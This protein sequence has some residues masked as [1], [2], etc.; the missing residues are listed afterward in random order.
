MR[1]FSGLIFR[2]FEKLILR[3]FISHNLNFNNLSIQSCFV[4]SGARKSLSHVG[5]ARPRRFF[6]FQKMEIAKNRVIKVFVVCSQKENYF[7]LFKDKCIEGSA[8]AVIVDQGPWC[9]LEISSH[10][11]NLLINVRP[12]RNPFPGTEQHKFRTFCPDFVLF[13]SYALGIHF[14]PIFAF[15]S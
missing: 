9:D 8:V 5:G 6:F 3:A 15:P 4:A 2:N 1:L 10:H 14:R 7:Q 11:T 12:N 13:R